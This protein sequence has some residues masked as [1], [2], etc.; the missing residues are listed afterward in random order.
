MSESVL[1]MKELLIQL[2]L[3][4]F[5]PF[6][7]MMGIAGLLQ[8]QQKYHDARGTFFSSFI[9]LFLGLSSLIYD[10]DGWSVGKKIGVHFLLMCVTVYPTLLLSGWFPLH[11]VTD[12]LKVFGYF[13]MTGA[14][15]LAVVG[16]FFLIKS[17][18]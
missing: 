11:N 6:G 9:V 4:G 14:A 7:I 13:V 16:L 5:V 2:L 18:L 12:A 15:I 1:S 3:R 8:H 10:I 17:K